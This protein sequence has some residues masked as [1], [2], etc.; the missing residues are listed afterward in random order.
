MRHGVYVIL[1]QWEVRLG[2][3]LAFF[4]ENGLSSSNLVICVC[5]ELYA[6]K[7]DEGKS[8]AGYEKRILSSDM[9]NGN[10]KHYI[11]PI[12]KNNRCT[13]KVP[14]FLSGLYYEDFDKN[15]YYLSY[16]NVIARIYNEDIKKKPELGDNPFEIS[17]LSNFISLKL[18]L[19]ETEFSNPSMSG[20]FSFDYKKHDG[21]FTIGIGANEF[22]TMWSEAGN[23]SI[24]CYRDKIYRIGYKLGC[25]V[26]PRYEDIGKE[27]DF[28]S[29][30]KTLSVGEVVILENR[31]HRFAAI[32]VLQVNRPYGEI[33]HLVKVEYMIYDSQLFM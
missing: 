22:I 32:K 27:F 2:D 23:D 8:G 26:F 15:D 1:D 19:E 25:S 16:R 5:S 24:H 21:I 14:L 3:D 17:S 33:G 12:I 18:N 29:R 20:V 4:M 13:N 10:N 7:A 9:I 30:A 31:N 11:I 28:S 6:K